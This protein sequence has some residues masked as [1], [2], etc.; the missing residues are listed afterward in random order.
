MSVLDGVGAFLKATFITKVLSLLAQIVLGIYLSQEAFGVYGIV[1]SLTVFTNCFGGGILQK[2]LVQKGKSFNSHYKYVPIAVIFSLVSFFILIAISWLPRLID[3]S[4][5]TLF[6]LIFIVA[7]A[8]I[9]QCLVP[10]QKAVLLSASKFKDV[11]E[12]ETLI[13]GLTHICTIPLCLMGFGPYSFVAHKPLLHVYEFF[14]Y[15]KILRSLGSRVVNLPRVDELKSINFIEVFK[16]FKWLFLGAF[17]T[18]FV[19]KGDYLV[20]SYFVEI[21]LVGIYF[22]SYQLSFSVANLFTA[23]ILNNVLLPEFSNQKSTAKKN[24]YLAKSL[25][26][27][28][29]IFS[30]LFFILGNLSGGM[31]EFIWGNKW[32]ESILPVKLLLFVMPL[33]MITPLL[34]VY[35]ESQGKWRTS[36][37]LTGVS[38]IG[39]LIACI[40]GGYSNTI[41][42]IAISIASWFGLLGLI[43]FALIIRQ[44]EPLFLKVRL[45]L[46]VI[47]TAVILFLA[48]KYFPGNVTA[49]LFLLMGL[50]IANT[51]IVF[52]L[53][54]PV[55]DA[56]KAKLSFFKNNF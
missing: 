44:I 11:A 35:L 19:I 46:I 22:F 1:L 28:V 16:E 6:F 3:S 33:R 51:Y 2:V 10:I 8:G 14:K 34:R 38:S 50:S 25:A 21:K 12:T 24:E 53:V 23:S 48:H 56:V 42:G 41:E 55:C 26:I 32:L 45:I 54:G 17:F 40:I 49:H 31:I 30:P 4:K 5:W 39:L 43:S 52:D 13:S 29:I 15:N 18:A 36:A 37:I 7:L 9:A 27:F 47:S 20:L